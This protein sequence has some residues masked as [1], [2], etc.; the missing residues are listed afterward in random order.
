[1]TTSFVSCCLDVKSSQIRSLFFIDDKIVPEL[2]SKIEKPRQENWSKIGFP[3]LC[4][5]ESETRQMDICRPSFYSK[6]AGSTQ[7]RDC[8]QWLRTLQSPVW[9]FAIASMALC[10]RSPRGN[11]TF[12]AWEQNLSTYK[13]VRPAS[14]SVTRGGLR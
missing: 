14:P 1:M 11:N 4:I 8:N 10:I 12:P 5:L 13:I 6:Q 3:R 9:H 2:S 7:K